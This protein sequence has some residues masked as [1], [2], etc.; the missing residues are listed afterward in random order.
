MFRLVFYRWRK[1]LRRT[2]PQETFCAKKC[3]RLLHF[4]DPD[5]FGRESFGVDF[6]S[7]GLFHV[8]PV[9][10]DQISYPTSSNAHCLTNEDDWQHFGSK[11]MKRTFVLHGDWMVLKN[12]APESFTGPSKGAF[13]SRLMWQLSVGQFVLCVSQVK[14]A[15]RG[16]SPPAFCETKMYRHRRSHSSNSTNNP[17]CYSIILKQISH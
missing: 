13:E 2:L 14:D 7:D 5:L 11:L 1:V 17:C 4:V 8:S 12:S 3:R 16:F 15:L 6:R 9:R 10:D